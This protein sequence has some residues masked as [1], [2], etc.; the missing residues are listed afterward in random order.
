M[1]ILFIYGMWCKVLMDDNSRR[2]FAEKLNK[3]VG[4]ENEVFFWEKT[5]YNKCNWWSHWKLCHQHRH[6]CWLL[7]FRFFFLPFSTN[8]SVIFHSCHSF[9]VFL[10]E[11]KKIYFFLGFVFFIFAVFTL[12]FIYK[13]QHLWMLALLMFFFSLILSKSKS[14]F[15][16]AC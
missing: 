16:N 3:I 8:I 1:A 10:C 7:Q 9:S 15:W 5:G 12:S 11:M 13:Q 14:K 2:V 4:S 6:Q